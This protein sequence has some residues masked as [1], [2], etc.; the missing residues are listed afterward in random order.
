MWWY[1]RDYQQPVLILILRW[2]KTTTA[3]IGV[4]FSMFEID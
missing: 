2:E 4:D 1:T 3:N